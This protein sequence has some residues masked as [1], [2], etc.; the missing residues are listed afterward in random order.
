MKALKLF[1][2][3][4]AV[5]ISCT[6]TSDMASD[7][8]EKRPN[9]IV[10]VGDDLGWGATGLY[11]KNNPPPMP[12]LAWWAKK[13]VVFSRA[14]G[15][16]PVGRPSRWSLL[17]GKHTGH[18]HI[19]GDRQGE[20]DGSQRM[21]ATALASLDY[22]SWM[23][24]YWGLGAPDTD[25]ESYSPLENG[26]DYAYGFMG[27]R[28]KT[29]YDNE[30]PT[31]LPGGDINDVFTNKA[32]ER[33]K[34]WR[35]QQESSREPFFLYLSYAPSGYDGQNSSKSL[36]NKLRRLDG[37]I[38]RILETLESGEALANTFVIFTSDNGSAFP[39]NNGGLRGGKRELYEG[40]LR[41]PLVLWGPNLSKVA[42]EGVVTNIPVASW[43]IVPTILD[44]VGVPLDDENYTSGIRG[45]EKDKL[46]GSSLL[47]LMANQA[48]KPR[49][50]DHLYWEYHQREGLPEGQ[51]F[52]QAVL[53]TDPQ[54]RLWKGVRRSD[55]IDSMAIALYQ[56]KGG[57]GA[58]DRENKDQAIDFPEIGRAMNERM[59]WGRERHSDYRLPFDF[60]YNFH[61]TYNITNRENGRD[62]WKAGEYRMVFEK[63]WMPNEFEIHLAAGKRKLAWQNGQMGTVPAS[64]G[65]SDES[66][67]WF[68]QYADQGHSYIINA[69]YG[70]R[71]HYAGG[72]KGYH[73]RFSR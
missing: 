53:W 69:G 25:E 6:T 46:D 1:M 23:V 9:I 63:N 57:E 70:N 43:D 41:V 49:P 28:Q 17:T 16:S 35:N 51:V 31:P 56:L 15:G 22:Q 64:G 54:G 34:G 13:G 66:D 33:L 36:G 32:L 20:A 42:G 11:S 8:A 2:L 29:L 38:N 19:R 4:G 61:F 3:V 62:I 26:F 39:T 30:D 14:Y 58:I 52:K 55:A 12:Y 40:G 48:M 27:H 10:I 68:I 18:L 37:H 65:T 71:L 50:Q 47:P 72:S 21:V 5:A 73:W 59:F 67:K 7:T 44:I 45:S 24:G 60:R